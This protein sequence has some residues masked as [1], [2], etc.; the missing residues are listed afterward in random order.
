MSSVN[1]YKLD[2]FSKK[3]FSIAANEAIEKQNKNV[4]I[5]DTTV[6][7][8]VGSKY[9]KIKSKKNIDNP[10]NFDST[11]FY[12]YGISDIIYDSLFVQD[13]KK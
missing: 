11:K 6:N 7:K 10:D 1:Q 4:V 5:A 9:D 2:N 13:F 12:L 8:K 3:T